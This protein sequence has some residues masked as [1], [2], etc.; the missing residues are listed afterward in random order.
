MTKQHLLDWQQVRKKRCQNIVLWVA[1][2]GR[3]IFSAR[4]PTSVV[5]I[6][7]YSGCFDAAPDLY[8]PTELWQS[9][10]LALNASIASGVTVF[11]VYPFS[12]RSPKSSRTAPNCAKSHYFCDGKFYTLLMRSSSCLSPKRDNHRQAFLKQL[13]RCC[14]AL[15]HS[16]LALTDEDYISKDDF[17]YA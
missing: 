15:R 5:K 6:Y 13:R 12:L 1:F 16:A 10:A 17:N 14:G 4:R 8:Q 9:A 11:S 2:L 7:P 3:Q